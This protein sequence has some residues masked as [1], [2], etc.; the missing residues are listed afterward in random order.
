[1]N[2]GDQLIQIRNLKDLEKVLKPIIAEALEETGKEVVERVAREHVDKDVYQAYSPKVYESTFELRDSIFTKSADIKNNTIEVVIKHDTDKINSY[3]PNQ[4]Y[5]VVDSYSRKDVSDWIPWIVHEGKT[6]D[7]WGDGG[8]YLQPRPYMD[9]AKDE[10]EQ[11]KE[12][13]DDLV[14][15]LKSLGLNAKRI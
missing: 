3:A 12:H 2:E 10:L 13:V 15:R 1:M 9:N 8:T 4:H 7:I 6:A 11:T 14:K 5:S